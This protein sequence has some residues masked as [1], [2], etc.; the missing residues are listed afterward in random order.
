M[1]EA[2][3]QFCAY[4]QRV[5]GIVLN[6][7]KKYLVESR[8]LPIVRRE[9]LTGLAQLVAVLERGRSPGLV[10]DVIHAMTIN[11]TYFFRDKSPFDLVSER[12]LPAL[13]T[14]RTAADP[15]RVWSAACST[16]QEPYSLS[17]II[18]ERQALLK[19]RR[20]EI[21]ATDVS[22]T[23]LAKAKEGRYSVFEVERG[24]SPERLKRHFQES[25][26]SYLIKPNLKE[27]ISFRSLNLL[28]DYSAFGPFD[29]ILCRNVLIYFTAA[30]KADI[31]RR[32]GR[33]LRPNGY[34]MLG[35][36]E[37]IMGLSSNLTG[38]PEFKGCY[39]RADTQGAS[40]VSPAV[41][42]SPANASHPVVRTSIG[43]RTR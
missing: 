32:L 6:E 3:S 34:L 15:I 24:L 17:M 4:L 22:E 11:E 5:C 1:L 31:L 21:I 30:Q 43:I 39:R 13:H 28:S 19:G 27:R 20:V 18:E 38:D 26:G 14:A 23:V 25:A 2:Y 35:A 37:S 8:V 40:D 16:G 10:Q 9:K 33:A 36:S 42:R 29:F 41:V 12:I 7:E